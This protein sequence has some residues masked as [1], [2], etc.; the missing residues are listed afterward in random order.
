MPFKDPKE[1][2]AWR[3]RYRAQWYSHHRGRIRATRPCP[4]R[5]EVCGALPTGKRR[6]DFDHCHDREVFR[7]WLCNPCNMALGNAKDDPQRLRAL[8]TYIENFNLTQ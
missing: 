2:A 6:L 5:C 4:E 1:K 8:A 7:G 3:R